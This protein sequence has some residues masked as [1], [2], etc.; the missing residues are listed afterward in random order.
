MI[1]ELR[2]L[3][4]V[5]VKRLLLLSLTLILSWNAFSQ[6]VTEIKDTTHI[7]LTT[8]VARQVA[9]D[10]VEGDQAKAELKLTNDKVAELEN[11]ITLQDSLSVMKENEVSYLRQMIELQQ[12][13]SQQHQQDYERLNKEIKRQSA[14]KT[15]FAVT[16]GASTAALIAVLIV[17]LLK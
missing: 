16:T 3:R 15:V 5:M 1:T 10:L 14:V 9:V 2:S 8:E 7:V 17:N 6:N 13:Q 11:L 12:L 4:K